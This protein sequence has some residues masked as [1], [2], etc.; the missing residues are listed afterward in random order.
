MVHAPE[1][2]VRVPRLKHW[3]I[4]GW[5]PIPNEDY[6]WMPPRQYS[7]G[8]DWEERTRIGRDA[9]VRFGILKE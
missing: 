6:G 5:Y 7:R 4:N 3:M 9:L 1:N 8:K 2:L